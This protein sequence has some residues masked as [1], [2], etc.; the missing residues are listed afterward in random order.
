MGCAR[1]NLTGRTVKCRPTWTIH[2]Y[3]STTL[4]AV[5]Q[6][7]FLHRKALIYVRTRRLRNQMTGGAGALG[8]TADLMVKIWLKS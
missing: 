6:M 7:L 8:L 4:H 1:S 2:Q 3:S 5:F